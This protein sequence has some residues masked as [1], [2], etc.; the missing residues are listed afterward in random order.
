MRLI[1]CTLWWNWLYKFINQAIN[2]PCHSLKDCSR[3]KQEN[4][5]PFKTRMMF[6]QSF[7]WF[8]WI[9]N[10]SPGAKAVDFLPMWG[11]LGCRN[12]WLKGKGHGLSCKCHTLTMRAIW[13]PASSR[14][15]S[16]TVTVRR[17]GWTDMLKSDFLFKRIPLARTF[18]HECLFFF[19]GLV[20]LQKYAV[21][22]RD[23]NLRKSPHLWVPLLRIEPEVF[24]LAPRSIT[25]YML[26]HFIHAKWCFILKAYS[27]ALFT[28]KEVT[29]KRPGLLLKTLN[30]NL[31]TA[32][33]T[34]GQRKTLN[35]SIIY[36][37]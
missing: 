11:I 19:A 7:F 12:G 21:I 36:L 28:T 2:L 6:L 24:V 23:G 8:S 27:N 17:S 34:K 37:I 3:F 18:H 20:H 5:D 30:L 4:S 26:N 33:F 32:T 9:Y 10:F 31:F 29:G 22:A 16:G 35:M 15:Q 25:M 1:K 13:S 14:S